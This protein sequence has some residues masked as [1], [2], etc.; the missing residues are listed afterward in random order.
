M[1]YVNGKEMQPK[2][3]LI[4][5]LLKDL[6]LNQDFI[7]VEVNQEIVQKDHYTKQLLCEGDRIEIVRFVGGG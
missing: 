3:L 7:V 1:I 5:D 2:N 6:E 4:S